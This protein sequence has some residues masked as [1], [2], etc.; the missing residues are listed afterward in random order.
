[1]VEGIRSSKGRERTTAEGRK[2]TLKGLPGLIERLE[3]Q[4]LLPAVFDSAAL[5]VERH[6][7]RGTGNSMAFFR[8]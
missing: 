2:E 3:N 6:G 7:I 8:A 5:V 1:V 4:D